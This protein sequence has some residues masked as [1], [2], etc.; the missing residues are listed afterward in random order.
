MDNELVKKL[1]TNDILSATKSVTRLLSNTHCIVCGTAFQA[2]RAG[3]LYCST[4]CKQFGYNHKAE[5]YRLVGSKGEGI[6]PNPVIFFIDDFSQYDRM[7]KSLRR[8]RDLN[9]KKLLWESIN[10]ELNFRQKCS[11]PI[12]NFLFDSYASKKLSDKEEDDLFSCESEL[13]ERI[14]DLNPKGLSLEQWS[15]LRSMHF[16]LDE[17]SFFEVVCSLSSEFLSRL[18]L[19]EA[20]PGKLDEYAVINNRFIIHCNLI[21]RG[22]IQFQK[23][24]LFEIG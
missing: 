1:D 6:N 4:R 23:K 9:K 8:F 16:S 15:F 5:I 7:Q 3:K 13:D 12:S 24:E 18:T 14:T 19:S 21:A 11:L 20:V 22:I 17:I 10:E 2:A